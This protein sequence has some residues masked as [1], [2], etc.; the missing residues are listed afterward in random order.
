MAVVCER[1]AVPAQLLIPSLGEVQSI[2][3]SRLHEGVLSIRK[4]VK[5]SGSPAPGHDQF[6]TRSSTAEPF[7]TALVKTK[8]LPYQHMSWCDQQLT[9]ILT[10]CSRIQHR[11]KV[12]QKTLDTRLSAC[13]TAQTGGSRSRGRADANIY[14]SHRN[15]DVR[16]LQ[17]SCCRSAERAVPQGHQHLWHTGGILQ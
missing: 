15:D 7:S 5:S 6:L 17:G 8:P 10:T 9:T 2:K 12:L 1:I 14:A 13:S 4:R 11:K 3:P 16:G